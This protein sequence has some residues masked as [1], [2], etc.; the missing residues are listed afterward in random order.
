MSQGTTFML[1]A[2]DKAKMI[3][4]DERHEIAVADNK[5]KHVF[6]DITDE[7]AAKEIDR[8]N[9]SPFLPKYRNPDDSFAE[10]ERTPFCV[11]VEYKTARLCYEIGSWDFTSDFLEL[12][13]EH[14]NMRT[15]DGSDTREVTA[16]EARQ[17][18]AVIDYILAGTYNSKMEREVFRTNPFFRVFENQFLS[19]AE[20]FRGRRR[21]KGCDEEYKREMDELCATDTWQA[22]QMRTVLSAFLS[23]AEQDY[24]EDSK[25]FEYK[26]VY[27][28][29]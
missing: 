10:F 17:M 28:R 1:M 27:L 6:G 18:L 25:H 21:G 4:F 5:R 16:E 23:L 20:R 3:G 12:S 24:T 19:F 13:D 2:V 22:Q 7:Q 9:V 26:L 8:G 11:W 29:W 15:C 14:W